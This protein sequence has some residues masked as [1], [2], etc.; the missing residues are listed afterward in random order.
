MP[1]DA[2]RK[3]KVCIACHSLDGSPRVGPVP[4]GPSPYVSVIATE[5]QPPLESLVT[6]ALRLLT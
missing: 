3:S 2:L 5:T 1:G 4:R 6:E